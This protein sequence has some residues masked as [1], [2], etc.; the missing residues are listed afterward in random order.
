LRGVYVNT[1]QNVFQ[2]H[3]KL[4]VRSENVEVTE[5]KNE[6]LKFL[7]ISGSKLNTSVNI[8]N[9]IQEIHRKLL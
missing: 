8:K 7:I 9:E 2:C 1:E 4:Y 3:I 5:V 6:D